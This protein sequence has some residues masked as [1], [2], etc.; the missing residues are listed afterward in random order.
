MRYHG[1]ASLAH[2]APGDR[3]HLEPQLFEIDHIPN[4]RRATKALEDQAAHAV[5]IFVL[6]LKVVL[7]ADFVDPGGAGDAPH[8]GRLL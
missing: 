2:A 7:L 6:E 5:D 3:Q 1:Y 8:A 4:D